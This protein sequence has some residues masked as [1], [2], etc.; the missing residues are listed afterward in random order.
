[1]YDESGNDE[2]IMS[3]KMKGWPSLVGDELVGNTL[4]I[5]NRL[6]RFDENRPQMAKPFPDKKLLRKKKTAAPGRTN[7]HWEMAL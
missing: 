4:S 5:K 6:V 3:E 1:M 7:F 2:R